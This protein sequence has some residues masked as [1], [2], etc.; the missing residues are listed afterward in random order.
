[1]DDLD[2]V[3]DSLQTPEVLELALKDDGYYE[4][5]L[6]GR[7][8]RVV[9]RGL[10][11]AKL[12]KEADQFAKAVLVSAEDPFTVV[13]EGDAVQVRL[14]ALGKHWQQVWGWEECVVPGMDVTEHL[15]LLRAMCDGLDR[16]VVMFP[17]RWSSVYGVLHAEMLNNVVRRMRERGRSAEFHLACQ[18]R[19]ERA[20]LQYYST[21]DYLEGLFSRHQRLLVVR[22]D[23][24]YRV[25]PTMAQAQADMKNF[26]DHQQG[27]K[28]LIGA[29]VG[30]ICR[31][32]CGADKGLH[33][34]VV[35][36]FNGYQVHKDAQRGDLIGRYWSQVV[37]EG[38]GLYFSCNCKQAQYQFDGI[39]MVNWYTERKRR[40]LLHAVAFLCKKD[41]CLT[42]PESEGHVFYRGKMVMGFD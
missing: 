9:G 30:H 13:R 31:L 36:L 1:M 10:R 6:D 40:L 22:M 35:L 20:R 15:G 41:E 16:E 27:N 24:A 21:V 42:P 2:Q 7:I 32:K 37:T 3:F 17:Q 38:R 28:D 14:G 34:H 29:R 5:H 4:A 33:F 18:R 11:Y 39:G 26:L 8:A 23:L 19:Q 12:L 25:R